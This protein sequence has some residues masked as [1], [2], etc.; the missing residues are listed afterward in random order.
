LYFKDYP[1]QY[2]G[3]AVAGTDDW[4]AIDH[5]QETFR[6][7][8]NQMEIRMWTINARYNPFR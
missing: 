7:N 4:A 6:S 1:G 5:N 8:I 3:I 2:V